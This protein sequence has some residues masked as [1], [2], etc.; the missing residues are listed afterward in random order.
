MPPTLPPDRL[1]E[2][3][4]NKARKG[5]LQFPLPVGFVYG[6]DGGWELDPD[7]QVRERLQY[8]F[9]SFRKHLVVR[10][11]VRDLKLD[12][13]NLPVRVTSREGYGSLVWKTPSMSAAVVH[14]YPTQFWGGTNVIVTSRPPHTNK[15][16]LALISHVVLV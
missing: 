13:L 4:W 5:L 10:R 1:Y 6:A 11:V 16:R 3:R 2:G 12:G 14:S 7:T 15:S 9:A 8:V